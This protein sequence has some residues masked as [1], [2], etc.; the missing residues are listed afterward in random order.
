MNRS[1][2]LAEHAVRAGGDDDDRA[3]GP[4]AEGAIEEVLGLPARDVGREESED[5]PSDTSPQ[6]GAAHRAAA[7]NPTQPSSRAASAA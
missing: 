2:S 5:A 1:S 3:V 4:L 6:S 7:I